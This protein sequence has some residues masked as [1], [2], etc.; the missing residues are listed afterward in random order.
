MGRNF[1]LGEVER[2]VQKRR[3]LAAGDVVER[4]VVTAAAASRH[5]LG[6]E[7]LD[8]G[9]ELGRAYD[10]VEVTVAG[11]GRVGPSVHGLQH[12]DRHLVAAHRVG[13]TVVPAAAA[14]GDALGRER[15]DPGSEVQ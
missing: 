8:P 13:R 2:V 6:R 15:V 5:A 12:E 9:G 1:D 7:L 3:H 10:V 14:A 11:R 4:A